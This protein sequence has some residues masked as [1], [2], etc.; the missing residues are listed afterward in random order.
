MGGVTLTAAYIL[1]LLLLVWLWLR[2]S[3]ATGV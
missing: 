1:P 2:G 3:T